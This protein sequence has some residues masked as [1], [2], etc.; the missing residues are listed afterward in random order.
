MIIDLLTLAYDL[1]WGIVK[2][3]FL[4][5]FCYIASMIVVDFPCTIIEAILKKQIPEEIPNKIKTAITIILTLI[6][7][8]QIR[9]R[10]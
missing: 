8:S 1:F 4:A 6:I 10:R 7:S 2:L 5:G 3:G 9:I